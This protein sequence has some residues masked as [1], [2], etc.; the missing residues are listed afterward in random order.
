MA[1]ATAT[2]TAIRES[3][4]AVVVTGALLQRETSESPGATARR[5]PS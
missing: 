3:G 2:A 5:S 4:G 1:S